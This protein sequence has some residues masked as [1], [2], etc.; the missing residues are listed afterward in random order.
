PAAS[1]ARRSRRAAGSRCKARAW[2]WPAGAAHRTAGKPLGH[3]PR[4]RRLRA[5]LPRRPGARA[6]GEPG[7]GPVRRALRPGAERAGAGTSERRGGDLAHSQRSRLGRSF[8]PRCPSSAAQGERAD[9]RKASRMIR[10]RHTDEW[11]GLLVVA[12]VAIFI[13]VALQ[14][15]VLR[16]WFRPA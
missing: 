10:L 4:A 15:G 2:I 6:A 13:G 1:Y 9:A 12:A 8:C 11:V 3:R 5:R 7:A 16:D 14:A